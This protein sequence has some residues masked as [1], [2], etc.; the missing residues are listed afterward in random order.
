MN[1]KIDTVFVLALITLFAATSFILVLIGAKQYRH[2]T[3]TMNDNYEV[4][5]TSSYIAEKIRQNDTVSSVSVVT[6]EGVPSL[7]IYS[8]EENITFMTYIYYYDNAL[9][10]LMVTSSSVF[11]LSSGQEIIQTGGFVPSMT[12][13]S[14]LRADVTDTKGNIHTFYFHL[15]T[16]QDKTPAKA[17]LV[18]QV[19]KEAS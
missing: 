9:R 16:K 8:V 7:C 4:R 5:T 12:S 1:K 13:P 14:L 11:D 10:E 2:I 19:G 17:S 6:L 3:N 15:H 18:P